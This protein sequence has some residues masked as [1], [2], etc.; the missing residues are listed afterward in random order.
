LLGTPS[1]QTSSTS[2]VSAENSISSANP[3][4]D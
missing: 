1:S 3:Q 2:T 4:S